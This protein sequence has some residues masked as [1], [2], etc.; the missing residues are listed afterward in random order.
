MDDLTNKNVQILF[1]TGNTNDFYIQEY[2]DQGLLTLDIN[3]NI[4][5]IPFSSIIIIKLIEDYYVKT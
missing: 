1:S 2:N 4:C 3:N 5:F